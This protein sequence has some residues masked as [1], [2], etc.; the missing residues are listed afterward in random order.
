MVKSIQY[1]N[2]ECVPVFE[3]PCN[4]SYATSPILNSI[5][6]FYLDYLQYAGRHILRIPLPQ[7]EKVGQLRL[8][9]WGAVQYGVYFSYHAAY[10]QRLLIHALAGT[11]DGSVLYRSVRPSGCVS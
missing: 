11:P 8:G 5:T 1:F 7:S 6:V 10:V 9:V 4:N 3:K 2:E